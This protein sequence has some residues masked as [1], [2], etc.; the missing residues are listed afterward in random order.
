[1]RI[2]VQKTHFM[3]TDNEITI[4]VDVK[5]LE[6]E[7]TFM[8]LGTVTTNDSSCKEDVSCRL[9]KPGA[10]LMDYG[11]EIISNL[12]PIR[13]FSQPSFGPLPYV[14]AKDGLLTRDYSNSVF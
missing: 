9:G 10:V 6:Q 4:V 1:M 14:V 12:P 5:T 3:S 8:Y 11:D 2:N 13:D 7:M